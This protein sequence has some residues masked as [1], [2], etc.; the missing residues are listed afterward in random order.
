MVTK[1]ANEKSI[2]NKPKVSVLT[3][4]YNT[5]PK[6]LREC[7]ESILNQTFKDFE[8]IILS[9]SPDN[10]ELD[11][12][13]KSY[14]DDRIKYFKNEQNLGI[15]ATRNKLLDL[16]QGDYVAMF[17]HDDISVSTRL[18][19]EVEYLDKNPEV[20]VVG[21][22]TEWFK[23][24]G[25]SKIMTCPSEDRDIRCVLTDDC[26]LAHTTVMLRRELL[27]KNQIKYR[28]YF[29]PCEDYQLFNELL[30]VTHFY[31]LNEVL[32]RYRIHE[33]QESKQNA[34]QMRLKAD[35]IRYDIRNRYPYYHEMYNKNFSE[36]TVFRLRLFGVI[37]FLKI[38]N[39][40]CYLFE[41][42][43]IFKARWH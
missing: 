4:I 6:H 27:V 21:A 37:P 26:Y 13:V 3:P 25:A 39:N 5:N 16:A 7:I 42:L 40:W 28:A 19:K 24:D 18:Q 2:E 34:S 41:F 23:P 31:V 1:S 43:P 38:K 22:N 11:E 33:G 36:R 8:F 12:I 35:A 17:D 15:S 9:D 29:S 14:S 10:K 32:V 20:G 30:D